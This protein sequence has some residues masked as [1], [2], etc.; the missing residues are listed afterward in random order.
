MSLLGVIQKM[1]G[2]N[3]VLASDP[4]GDIQGIVNTGMNANSTNDA[5]TQFAA[6]P[7]MDFVKAAQYVKEHGGDPKAACAELFKEKGMNIDPNFIGSL[8]RK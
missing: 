3:T 2:N 6:N 4:M 8:M 1:Q 7:K 5:M